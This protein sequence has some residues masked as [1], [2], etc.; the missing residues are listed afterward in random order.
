MDKNVILSVLL[1]RCVQLISA[2]NIKGAIWNHKNKAI[3]FVAV[4]LINT[5]STF[6]QGAHTLF[7]CFEFTRYI[8]A[9]MPSCQ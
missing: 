3:P 7:L 4:R 2:Q 1:I 9:N 8:A 5:D 6:I